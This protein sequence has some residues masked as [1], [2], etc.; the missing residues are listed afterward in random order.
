MKNLQQRL[1]PRKG[2][3]YGCQLIQ[4]KLKGALRFRLYNQYQRPIFWFS[5]SQDPPDP[6]GRWS[7]LISSLR[8]THLPLWLTMKDNEDSCCTSSCVTGAQYEPV[9]T[10]QSIDY[11][12]NCL[13]DLVKLVIPASQ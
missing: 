3:L 10:F 5:I 9:F 13:N 11:S 2:L 6:D 12:L 4:Y 1:Q 8:K 7:D